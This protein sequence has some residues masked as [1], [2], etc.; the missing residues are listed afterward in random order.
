MTKIGSGKSFSN[1]TSLEFISIGNKVKIGADAFEGCTSFKTIFYV[2]TLDELNA[3]TIVSLLDGALVKSYTEYKA[4][5]DKSGQYI[6]YNY[7]SCEAFNNGVHGEIA[8]QNPCVG[9]C[10]VCNDTIINHFASAPLDVTIEYADYTMVGVKVSVCQN[11]GCIYSVEEEAP[12][13]FGCLGYSVQNYGTGG[14]S[15]GFTVN[16]KAMAEYKEITGA[17][18]KYGVFAASFNKLGDGDIFENGVANQ[19]AVCAEIKAVE[20]SV[21]EIKITGFTDAQK[22]ALLALGAYVSV[23]KDGTTEYSYM[24]DDTKGNKKGNYYIVSYN[25]IVA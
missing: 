13:L 22:D 18:V 9:V 12:A 15:I 5:S 4:L 1:C 8:A 17:D 11:K 25:D 21:F 10:G 3:T 24:Q 2:G 14:I 23:T 19:N 6:V 7:S 20:F 16:N